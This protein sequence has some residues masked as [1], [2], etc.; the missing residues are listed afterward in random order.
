[1]MR[2]LTGVLFAVVALGFSPG[3]PAGETN[4]GTVT[5][6]VSERF[7]AGADGKSSTAAVPDFRRHIVPLLGR[8]GCNG[9]ACHGSFQGQGG[10]RLSLFGYDF[11]ADHAAL[12][13]GDEPR[14]SPDDPSSSLVLQKATLAV[15]HGGGERFE[16]GGWEYHLL[17]TWIAA[18]AEPVA[19]AA[20]V[21][22]LVALD[23]VPTEVVFTPEGGSR[24]LR[25]IARWADGSAED[26]TPLC[27]FQTND[28]S[29][30]TVSAGGVVTAAGRGDTHVVVFYDGGITPVPVVRPVSDFTGPRYPDVPT[31]TRIDEMVVAKLRKVGLVPS[32]LCT[33]A[34]FLRRVSLDVTGTLPTPAEI[35]AFLADPS[36]EKRER[37][38]D[39][40]LDSPAYS[41]WWATRLGDLMGNAEENL[42]VGGE[43]GLRQ[44]KS[45]QWYDWLERRLRENAAYYEIVGRVVLA[46]SR[47]P[48]Q[49]LDDYFAATSAYFRADA[50]AD[51]ADRETMPY[52]W[53]RGRFTPPQPLRFSY[54]FL[55]VRLECAQCHKHP[56]D[57]WTKEDYEQFQAFF[58][59]VDYNYGSRDRAA[60]MKQKLGLTADQDSGGYKKLFADLAHRGTVVPW[61]EVT[62]PTPKRQL[63]RARKRAKVSGGRVFTPK[64]L[65]GPKVLAAEYDDAREPLMEWLRG[66]D[67]PYFAPALVNRVWADYFG[68]GLIDP[69]DDLNLA[70]PPS[71][72]P[73]L[74][75]LAAAFVESGYDLKWLH[76]EIARSRTYQ[77]SWRPNETNRLDERNFSRAQVRRLPAEVA[78]D[79]LVHATAG[80]ETMHA[81]HQD[82][83]TVRG[84]AI[85]VATGFTSTRGQSRSYALSLFGKPARD[86]ICDCQRSNEPSLLQ[87]IYLRNDAETL[88]LLDRKNGWLTETAGKGRT[89]SADQKDP[90]ALIREAYLRTFSRPPTPAEIKTARAHLNES[91]PKT[92]LRDLLWALL[93]S[94]E[95]ILNH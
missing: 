3:A 31:P 39:E 40:L 87:T 36:P 79:A 17:R 69:P 46:V 20:E 42:P 32:E 88:R 82:R 44:E 6:P 15:D 56:Y 51:F 41:A 91:D 8:L 68:V 16:R 73:L 70:N 43:Q 60:E 5:A 28:E 35:E 11:A 14:V 48:G 61:E 22:D 78:F 64:L 30:A 59:G 83:S 65:G 27:R 80:R 24:P 90:E 76:R 4:R 53:T 13:G 57:Q 9:R 26:V 66:P 34:E 45:A 84:R 29:V 50:P 77:L 85:G 18:G 86:G 72:A 55:G 47:P 94:K 2:P 62:I 33:D 52:F 37:K 63:E 49:S 19:D 12:A 71:N 81:M 75:Y 54:A 95:F 21:S 25:V 10:F 67:N 1:M 7:A 93:N 23:V 89:D 38:I 58:E 92:A 74:D